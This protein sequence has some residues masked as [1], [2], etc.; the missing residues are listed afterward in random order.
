MN[1][2]EF[3]PIVIALQVWG[4]EWAHSRLEFISDNQAVVEVINQSTTKDPLMFASLR[5]LML[6]SLRFNLIV[7]ASHL[8]DR[9]NLI[10][11]HLSHSQATPKFLTTHS[12]VPFSQVILGEIL[13]M[14]QLSQA[15]YMLLSLLGCATSMLSTSP[16]I[17]HEFY[18][19]G[20][21]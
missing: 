13:D 19:M 11:D 6:I 3:V 9:S 16:H 18:L 15:Y 17:T 14:M 20:S 8:P 2:K 5:Y 10:A 12:L 1:V 21:G 7:S 4:Q